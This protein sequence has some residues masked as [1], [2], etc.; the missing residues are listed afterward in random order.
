MQKIVKLDEHIW[1]AF[2]GLTAD[3]R[4]LLGKARVECQS[5]R[6]SLD[7]PVSVEYI[8]RY[9]ASVQQVCRID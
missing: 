6:L 3:A 2:A 4:V 8:A 7:D 9:I 1:T 5:H